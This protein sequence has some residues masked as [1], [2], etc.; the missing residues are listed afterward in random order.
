MLLISLLLLLLK[1]SEEKAHQRE[2]IL[3]DQIRHLVS[4]LKV[5]GRRGR[6][7]GRSAN[8]FPGGVSNLHNLTACKNCSLKVNF[9]TFNS[10]F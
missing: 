8:G 5:G 2:D 6:S 7:D 9:G 4:R 1:V 10:I 3:K